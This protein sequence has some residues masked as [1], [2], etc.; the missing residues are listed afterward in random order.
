MQSVVKNAGDRGKSVFVARLYTIL[1]IFVCQALTAL[2]ISRYILVKPLVIPTKLFNMINGSIQI[3]I[4]AFRLLGFVL[5]VIYIGYTF[6]SLIALFISSR[7][8]PI[9]ADIDADIQDFELEEDETEDEEQTLPPATLESPCRVS[10]FR[11]NT[12]LGSF[13]PVDVYLNGDWIGLA[14]PDKTLEFTT[15]V[16]SNLVSILTVSQQAKHPFLFFQAISGGHVELFMKG[17]SFQPEKNR[18]HGS[19]TPAKYYETPAPEPPAPEPPVYEQPAYE[20][21]VYEQP[22]CEPPALEPPTPKPP[23]YETPAYEPPTYEPPAP[24]LLASADAPETQAEPIDSSSV[25]TPVS[26]LQYCPSCGALKSES[27]EFCLNCGHSFG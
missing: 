8:K 6:G 15:E 26:L 21:P 18:F 4:D 1:I 16:E 17:E 13:Y 23:A 5:G 9:E 19:A 27:S 12:I 20:P 11:E 14:Y 10:I 22:A 2:F 25:S 3:D 24:E 7:G